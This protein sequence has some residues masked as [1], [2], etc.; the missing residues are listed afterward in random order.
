MKDGAIVPEIIGTSLKLDLR[1][2]RNN[3][4]H[5]LSKRAQAFTISIDRSLGNV[6]NCN[7]LVTTCEKVVYQSGLAT[8]NIDDGCRVH[9]CQIFYQAK[10][11]FKV[12]TV[13]A[14]SVRCSLCIYFVPMSLRVHEEISQS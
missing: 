13:P 6:Q 3:P 5:A 8:A 4:V 11:F 14:D 2:V 9:R 10:R 12:R 7:L 1:D